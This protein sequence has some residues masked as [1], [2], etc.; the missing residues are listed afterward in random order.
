M[1][2]E[3]RR[4]PA[5][6]TPDPTTAPG[7]PVGVPLQ[8]AVAGFDIGAFTQ[9]LTAAQQAGLGANAE[10]IIGARDREFRA[11]RYQRAFD[12]IEGLYIQLNTQ[13]ARHQAE[14]RRQEI[15]YKAGTLKMS[16]REWM[17]RQ[18]QATEQTQRID[19]AR[20]QFARVLD[21]LRVHMA[22]QARTGGD[23]DEPAERPATAAPSPHT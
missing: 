19:R 2:E 1:S 15:Q 21:G 7:P 6:V 23:A 18:R 13:A 4:E 10:A 20:R 3:N 11:G 14:L 8:P 17:Q 22:A 16:P 5:E 9:L 12:V